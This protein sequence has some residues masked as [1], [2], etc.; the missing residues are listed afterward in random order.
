[1]NTELGEP[2]GIS[3]LSHLHI[4]TLLEVNP[5]RLIKQIMLQ[6]LIRIIL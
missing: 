5:H 2:S 3:T 4:T 6:C 1:M